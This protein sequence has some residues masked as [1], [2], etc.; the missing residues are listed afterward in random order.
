MFHVQKVS[1]RYVF[2]SDMMFLL[3]LSN[4][5]STFDFLITPTNVKCTS[6]IDFG[7]DKLLFFTHK[8]NEE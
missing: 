2:Y 3:A 4:N 8:K 6:I 1:I 5:E 7:C